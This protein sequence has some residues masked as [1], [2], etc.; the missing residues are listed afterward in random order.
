M[1]Q[2]TWAA[3]VAVV[4]TLVPGAVLAGS[5]PRTARVLDYTSATAALTVSSA[6]QTGEKLQILAGTSYTMIDCPDLFPSGSACGYDAHRWNL[7]RFKNE[8]PEYFQKLLG[9]LAAHGCNVEYVRTDATD[10][11][12]AYGVVSVRPAP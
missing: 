11:S 7:G 2:H 6:A 5:S 12:G 3:L 9:D 8:S 1:K 10:T 4:T